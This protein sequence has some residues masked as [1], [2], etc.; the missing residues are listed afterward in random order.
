MQLMVDIPGGRL[1]VRNHCFCLGGKDRK[2]QLIHPARVS[3]IV[4]QQYG[5]LSAAAAGL[6]AQFQIPL[7]LLHPSYPAVHLQSG[8]LSGPALVRRRQAIGTRMDAPATLA[9][10]W[11]LKKME[12][13]K[14]NI[15]WLHAKGKLPKAYVAAIIEMYE[16]LCTNLPVQAP[17]MDAL[18]EYTGAEAFWAAQYW[19]AIAKALGNH[20]WFAGRQQRNCTD[21]LNPVL[22]YAYALLL[23]VTETQILAHGLDPSFGIVHADGYDSQP[24]VY[25]I[26]EPWRPM[27][28]RWLLEWIFEPPPEACWQKT[29]QGMR[30]SKDGRKAVAR[31]FFENASPKRGRG[32]ASLMQQVAAVCNELKMHFSQTPYE[33]YLIPDKIVKDGEKPTEGT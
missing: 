12:Q 23:H 8:T 1:T 2:D 26:M 25:D 19:K 28:D 14:Q 15:K 21:R 17:G 13:Q 11:L 4:V 32:H 31:L 22:N 29:Q 6:A 7:C 24:L 27:V 20:E 9:C 30:L 33:D 5:M 3:A 16:R 18:V 10:N